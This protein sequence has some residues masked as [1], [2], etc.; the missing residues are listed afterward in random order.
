[1]Q[2]QQRILRPLASVLGRSYA[3]GRT[4]I[5]TVDSAFSHVNVICTCPSMCSHL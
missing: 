3:G 5:L 2:Q 4:A 1:M